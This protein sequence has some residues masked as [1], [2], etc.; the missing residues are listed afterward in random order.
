M[1]NKD[2]ALSKLQSELNKDI[3]LATKVASHCGLLELLFLLYMLHF[4]RL[5]VYLP[6]RR[7]SA[8]PVDI[9][10]I[11]SIQESI[12]YS[13]S[14]V[15]KYG[16]FRAPKETELTFD[17]NLINSLTKI[18]THINSKYE[19]VWMVQFLDVEV[20]GERDEGCKIDMGPA[21]TDPKRKG[22]LEYFFRIEQDNN[23]KIS[24]M[25][26]P[27]DL[28]ENFKAEYLSAEHLFKSDTGMSLEVFC[29]QVATL[30][31]LITDRLK[32]VE[33]QLDELPN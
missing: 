11:N 25:F 21:M 8:A 22:L 10:A 26:E 12:K 7:K 24:M 9:L 30:L 33:D 16:K 29:N 14:L 3:M 2:R 18:T 20:F 23:N 13:V 17:N 32:A 31:Q 6:E 19:Y 5:F 4:S 28:L 15:L 1:D 27:N